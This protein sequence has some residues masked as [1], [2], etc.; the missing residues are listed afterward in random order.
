MYGIGC[1]RLLNRTQRKRLSRGLDTDLESAYPQGWYI[2]RACTMSNR[3]NSGYPLDRGPMTYAA[4]LKQ[5]A[6]AQE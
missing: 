6:N 3:Q 1:P 5:H 2:G 4:G